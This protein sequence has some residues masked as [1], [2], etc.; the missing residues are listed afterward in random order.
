MLKNLNETLRQLLLQT[1]GPQLANLKISFDIPNRDWSARVGDDPMV[2]LYLYDIRENL[3]LREMSWDEIARTNGKVMLKPQTVW[4]N[5]SYMVTCWTKE[6]EEQHRLL[7]WVL[8]TLY[9]YSPLP[10]DR[11]QGD[12]GKANRSVR[13]AVAQPNGV[14]KNVSEFWAALENQ[15]RPAIDLLVTLEL[16]INRELGAAAPP[17]GLIVDM[18]LWDAPEPAPLPNAF[19]THFFQSIGADNSLLFVMVR[20]S[21]SQPIAASVTLIGPETIGQ[22]RP[23]QPTPLPDAVGVYVFTPLAPGSYQLSVEAA[24]H[25]AV[26]QSVTIPSRSTGDP[27]LRVQVQQVEIAAS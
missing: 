25:S 3:E 20:D 5:L 7:W 1:V 9:R 24:G 27:V 16:D 18:R 13:T 23:L 11:L 8:E 4:V 22:E 15:I 19:T 17:K 2:N 26:Q 10:V 14:I 21:H 6:T 12:L